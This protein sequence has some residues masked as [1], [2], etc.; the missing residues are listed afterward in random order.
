[1]YRSLHFSLSPWEHSK[2]QPRNLLT[3]HCL[4]PRGVFCVSQQPLPIALLFFFLDSHLCTGK[5]SSQTWA[6]AA[7]AY[8]PSSIFGGELCCSPEQVSNLASEM[9]CSRHV[10]ELIKYFLEALFLNDWNISSNEIFYGGLL[11]KINKRYILGKIEKVAKSWVGV[12]R[13][14]LLSYYL[15]KWSLRHCTRVPWGLV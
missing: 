11:S 5:F 8:V 13:F 15:Y 1:M 10:C 14:P 3:H 6:R 9:L 4:L 2:H 12:A 7:E